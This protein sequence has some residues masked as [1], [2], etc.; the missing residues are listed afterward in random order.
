M[1]RRS[2]IRPQADAPGW[3]A[4]RRAVSTRTKGR[5]ARD[6]S[7]YF[8]VI[9]PGLDLIAFQQ[10]RGKQVVANVRSIVC[11]PLFTARKP[12]NASGRVDS[13]NKILRRVAS[14]LHNLAIVF[15]KTLR[16]IVLFLRQLVRVNLVNKKS[17]LSAVSILCREGAFNSI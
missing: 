13:K 4:A 8:V 6:S 10:V 11:W 15:I 12:T 5:A 1:S 17:F 9:D 14:R 2:S 3:Q 7:N 16:F